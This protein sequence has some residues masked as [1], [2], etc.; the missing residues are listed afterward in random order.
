MKLRHKTLS[1][2]KTSNIVVLT[3]LS[4]QVL[5]Q[6]LL[7]GDQRWLRKYEIVAPPPK[8]KIDKKA[9]KKIDLRTQR[10]FRL[11]HLFQKLQG[12]MI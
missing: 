7:E 11:R 4:S 1:R 6:K 8:K 2:A 9:W 12:P 10:L 5:R 3:K